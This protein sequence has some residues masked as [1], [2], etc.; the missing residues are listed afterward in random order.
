MD[1]RI[2]RR[3][4]F[5]A[6]ISVTVAAAAIL[7]LL[8]TPNSSE[9]DFQTGLNGKVYMCSDTLHRY[10][11]RDKHCESLERC[12]GVRTQADADEAALAFRLIACMVCY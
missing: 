12:H 8:F 7:W 4:R 11:H 10:Y 9:H 3:F 6:F 2:V 1:D 5:T